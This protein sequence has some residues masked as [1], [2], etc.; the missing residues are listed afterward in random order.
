ML[1]ELLKTP[2]TDENPS[3]QLS[4][5][6]AMVKAAWVIPLGKAVIGVPVALHEAYH[7]SLKARPSYLAFGR[8]SNTLTFGE[9]PLVPNPDEP[10]FIVVVSAEAQTR[11]W[12]YPDDPMHGSD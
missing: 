12:D 2:A 5:V 11:Q 8:A 4:R 1:Q 7:E 9:M 6:L 3:Q 10:D